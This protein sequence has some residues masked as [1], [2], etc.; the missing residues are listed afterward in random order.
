MTAG[1]EPRRGGILAA[2]SVR[3]S[4]GAPPRW[5][6]CTPTFVL[7]GG[8]AG[9]GKS[10]LAADLCRG[11]RAFTGH[12]LEVDGSVYA[13]LGVPL[14]W[15]QAA[16]AVPAIALVAVSG[17]GYGYGCVLGAISVRLPNA[18]WLVLNIG[19]G[20]VLTFC[21]VSVPVAFWPRP[22]RAVADVLP[23]THGLQ[24]IR[25]L[26]DGAPAGQVAGRLAL[27][28]AVGA[29]WFAG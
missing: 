19:Y 5:P 21:G 4:P 18:M 26:L 28:A 16:Y 8:E 2:W 10:R 6:R 20:V 24:A 13:L 17:Y 11:R 9:A 25:G 22:V 29:A 3:S 7:I 15:P 23:V 14:P 27:E 1:P 12:C